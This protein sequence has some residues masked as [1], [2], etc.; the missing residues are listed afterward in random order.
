MS[1][2]TQLNRHT[3]YESKRGTVDM[4]NQKI[5]RMELGMS[6]LY[7]S[8]ESCSFLCCFDGKRP[9]IQKRIQNPNLR[10]KMGPILEYYTYYC[11]EL[12]LHTIAVLIPNISLYNHTLKQTGFIKSTRKTLLVQEK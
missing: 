10:G 7:N 2:K 3:P 1:I 9:S 4:T 6:E 8:M 12:I 5:F 11:K